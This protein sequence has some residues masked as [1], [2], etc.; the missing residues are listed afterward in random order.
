MHG[1]NNGSGCPPVPFSIHGYGDPFHF[2]VMCPGV[3]A[4]EIGLWPP[5]LPNP[6]PGQR[7]SQIGRIDKPDDLHTLTADA[8][9]TIRRTLDRYCH[10]AV[11]LCALM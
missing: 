6:R 11:L 2:T 1:A 8:T 4:C 9:L 5:Q 7:F 10:R 3:F